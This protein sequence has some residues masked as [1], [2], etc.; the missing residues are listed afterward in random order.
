MKDENHILIPR[1]SSVAWH[2]TA[3]HC[4]GNSIADIGTVDCTGTGVHKR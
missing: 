3:G 1:K 4:G 2:S